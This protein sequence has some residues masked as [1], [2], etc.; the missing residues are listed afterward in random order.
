MN[1]KLKEVLI[2]GLDREARHV[3]EVV[4]G[5]ENGNTRRLLAIE[6]MKATEAFLLLLRNDVRKYWKGGEKRE[7]KFLL[8]DE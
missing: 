3:R 6:Q 7:W 8:E 5:L 2:K 4:R 1:D